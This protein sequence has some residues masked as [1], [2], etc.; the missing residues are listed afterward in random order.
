MQT[1]DKNCERFNE[2]QKNVIDIS[3][4]WNAWLIGNNGEKVETEVAEK[5]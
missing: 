2:Y 5:S 3:T 1:L 4:V